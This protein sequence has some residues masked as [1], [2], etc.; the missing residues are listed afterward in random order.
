MPNDLVRVPYPVAHL[1]KP[2]FT[3]PSRIPWKNT[4]WMAKHAAYYVPRF[5]IDKTLPFDVT[6][7]VKVMEDRRVVKDP[8]LGSFSVLFK[9][10]SRI[11]RVTT[12]SG[13]FATMRGFPAKTLG[14]FWLVATKRRRIRSNRGRGDDDHANVYLEA[15]S[16][17]ASRRGKVVAYVRAAAGRND[18]LQ[19]RRK[20]IRVQ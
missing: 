7:Q 19:S 8:H 4:K 5:E 1:K 6:I 2:T 18:P 10:G 17:H 11:G 12:P 3:G 20:T 15:K 9:K 16:G 13:P 14:R